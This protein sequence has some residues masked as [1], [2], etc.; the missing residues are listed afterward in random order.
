MMPL[1]SLALF[2]SLLAAAPWW[3]YRMFTTERY[4]EG[5]LQ[6]LGRVPMALRTY[7]EGKRT[8]WLHAVSVGEVLAA[9]SLIAQLQSEL[10]SELAARDLHHHAQPASSWPANASRRKAS[11]TS[12]SISVLPC[13]TGCARSSLSFSS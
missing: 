6:R 3:L 11:S 8:I 7:V 1:Y 10:G 13:A 9:S 2:L 12:R 5:L 4:R